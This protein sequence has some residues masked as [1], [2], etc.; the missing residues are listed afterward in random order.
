MNNNRFNHGNNVEANIALFIRV[1]K[2]FS[3]L[4]NVNVKY[5]ADIDNK[6]GNALIL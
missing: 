5:K 2:S 4:L 1:S 6:L 3:A